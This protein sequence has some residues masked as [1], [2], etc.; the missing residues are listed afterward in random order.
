MIHIKGDWYIE[1]DERTYNLMQFA[2]TYVDK[3]GRVCSSY[4]N[5]TYHATLEQALNQYV[6]YAIRDA[7]NEDDLEIKEAIRVLHDE[8]EK[9]KKELTVIT[10]GM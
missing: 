3:E 4:K 1:A 7:L 6:K 9:I 10:C 8:M 5:T 2:G